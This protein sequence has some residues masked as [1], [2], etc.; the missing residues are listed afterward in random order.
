MLR[1]PKTDPIKLA[2]L[3]TI[4]IRAKIDVPVITSFG[5]MSERTSLL[6]RAEDTDGVVGWGEIFGNFPIHGAENRKHIVEDYIAILALSKTWK[7]PLEAF[8]ALTAKTHVLTLQSGEPGPF[9]QSIAGVDIALWDL[10]ARRADKPLWKF[11]E[12]KGSS[13]STYASGLN[14]TGFENIVEQKIS[15]GYN[16]F[17]LKVGFGREEDLQSLSKIRKLI[18]DRRLMIDVNQGWDIATALENWTAYSEHNLQWIEEPISADRPLNE[19]EDLASQPGAPI[20]AGEN[21]L[22]DEQFDNYINSKCFKFLQPDMCKWG[23]FSKT[24]P[25]AKR[26]LCHGLTYC[27]HFLAGPIGLF[28]S[29]HCLAAA[30]GDG[31]LEID[32][33]FNPIRE[34]LVGG[35]P[36]IK[37]GIM[38]L[39]DMSGLGIYP[40]P[41]FIKKHAIT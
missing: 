15:E 37:N 39:P 41:E 20:A 35:L 21:L 30:G 31:L 1:L 13:I 29:A 32:A 36:L 12:G 11:L 16:A 34:H 10:A 5:V 3:E 4:L 26:S 7:S 8:N 18:G 9:A 17:K 19:W 27:P 28:A 24:L 6:V 38:T 33:N 40:D 14:P 25:L 23:G 22:G 2:K